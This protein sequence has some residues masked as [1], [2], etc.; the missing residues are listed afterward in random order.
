MIIT[1]TY[2]HRFQHIISEIV[3]LVMSFLFM[4]SSIMFR[5]KWDRQIKVCI[6]LRNIVRDIIFKTV[7]KVKMWIIPIQPYICTFSENNIKTYF[8]FMNRC[9]IDE[10][11][12]FTSIIHKLRK[13]SYSKIIHRIKNCTAHFASKHHFRPWIFNVTCRFRIVYILIFLNSIG[14]YTYGVVPGGPILPMD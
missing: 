12:V 3:C 9:G 5:A 6:Y 4:Y 1:S 10:Y 8:N 2:R 7:L 13:M 14:K 11:D